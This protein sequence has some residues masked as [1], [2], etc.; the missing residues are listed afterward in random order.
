LGK[1]KRGLGKFKIG[2][3]I[4]SAMRYIDTDMV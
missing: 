4:I 3:F 1:V 2:L